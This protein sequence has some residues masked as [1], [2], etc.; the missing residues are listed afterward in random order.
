MN[1]RGSCY[2]DAYLNRLR[3]VI[4]QINQEEAAL[5]NFLC[6]KVKAK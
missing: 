1:E 5:R 6:N 2:Y 3:K 4:A